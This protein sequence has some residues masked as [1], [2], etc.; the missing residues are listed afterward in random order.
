MAGTK[1]VNELIQ[2]L[3]S[4]SGA[5]ILDCKKALDET[6]YD[7]EKALVLL[8]ERGIVKA[9]SKTANVTKNGV[10]ASYIHPGDRIGVLLELNCETDFVARTDE[11]RNLAKELCLQ[12]AACSPKWVT[13]EDVPK[14]VLEQERDIYKK[15]L[16]QDEKNKNKPDDVLE[17]IVEGRLQ[18]FYEE[19]CLLEQPYIRDP[20]G[21]QKIKDLILQ[22]I[23]KLQENVTVRRFTRYVLGEEQ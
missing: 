23:S 20:Q 19:V 10:I 13:K 11:F 14:E 12:I 21:K 1:N 9:M 17:K 4:M 8:R 2:K 16:L 3:R 7:V 18:K 6:N 22:V 15:Q 5:G